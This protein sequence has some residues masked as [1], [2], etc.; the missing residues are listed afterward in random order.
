[1]KKAFMCGL[2]ALLATVAIARA[3]D[4]LGV[5]AVVDKVVFEPSDGP[6]ERIQVWGTFCLIRGGDS[7]D[8]TA[9]QRGY[10][11]FTLV[12]DKEEQCR[13]EWADLKNVA[14]IGECIAFGARNQKPGT[15]RTGGI[16]PKSADPYPL[17]L[18]L[19]KVGKDNYLS[20]QLRAAPSPVSPSEGDLVPP[21]AVTLHI[22]NSVGSVGSKVKYLFVIED[23]A[24][25]QEASP[26][27]APGEKETTWTPKMELKAGGKYSWRVWTRD[28]DKEDKSQAVTTQFKAKDKR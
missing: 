25:K 18:G 12:K 16:D 19:H 22:R 14:G 15:V 2:A 13:K 20:E 10:L 3:S 26:P 21:G 11:Y 5:F 1:M 24:G 7:V 8:Y 23:E 17:A 9:P 28:D 27:L 6:A 4:P